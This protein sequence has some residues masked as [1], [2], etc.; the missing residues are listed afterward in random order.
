MEFRRLRYFLVVAQEENITRAA[1]LLFISQP[2]LSRQLVQLEE[3]LGTQLI[4]R[5]KRKIT[6]TEAGMIL[7]NRAEEILALVEKTQSECQGFDTKINGKIFIGIPE[8]TAGEQ[9]IEL[10][11][12]FSDRYP[13]AT[14]DIFTGTADMIKDRMEKGL[15]D[16][17]ILMTP[18]E[19]DKFN[20]IQLE[21]KELWG[22]LLPT[23]CPLAEKEQV[24]LADLKEAPLLL[25][26]RYRRVTE[27]V[28]WFGE[29]LEGLNVVATFNLTTNAVLMVKNGMGYATVVGGSFL[30][31]SEK[32]ICFRP[33]YP[34]V[35]S[36][37]VLAWKKNQM[38]NPTVRKFLEHV[39]LVLENEV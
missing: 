32:K 12:S 39:R 4:I 13:E 17:G 25:S 9:V 28:D 8:S 36:N 31:E 20:A 29:E 24:T 35:Q 30:G 1:E 7:R 33:L 15:V 37:S 38:L 34:A 22:V 2:A 16:I 5:G 10:L 27:L 11:K 6:L 19:I 18:T 26:G 21:Q 23:S 14:F 3:E